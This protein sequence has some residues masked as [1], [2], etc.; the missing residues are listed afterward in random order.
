[1]YRSDGATEAPGNQAAITGSAGTEQPDRRRRDVPLVPAGRRGAA[2]AV[3]MGMD[4]S[5]VPAVDGTSDTLLVVE[6]DDANR[7]FLRE[8][9]EAEGFDVATARDGQEALDWLACHPSPTLI[10]L[11]LDMPRMNGWEFL[12]AADRL[13]AVAGTRVVVLTGRAE[14]LPVLDWVAKPALPE[15]LI[16]TL[17]WHVGTRRPRHRHDPST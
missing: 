3:G 10:L 14:H 2:F 16:E 15:Q 11:D 6:D 17:R 1:M 12:R 9:L 8:L 4:G 13:T 5:R 7:Q